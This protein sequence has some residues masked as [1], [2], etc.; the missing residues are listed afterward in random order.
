MPAH[1]IGHFFPRTWCIDG[2][3]YE[4]YTPKEKDFYT[5]DYFTKHALKYLDEYRDDDKPFFLYVAYTAPHDP[6]QAWPEDIQKYRGKFMAGYE[7]HRQERY[8]RQQEMGLID[9]S[10]PLSEPYYADWNALSEEEKAKEDTRMAIYSAMIDRV[11]QNIGKLLDKIAER[12]ELDNTLVIF[13]SDNGCAASS[14]G[15]YSNYNPTANQGAMGSMTRWTKLGRLK[16]KYSLMPYPACVGWLDRFLPGWSSQE[17]EKSLQLVRTL[18]TPNWDFHPE[19]VSHTW[20]IN[21]KT[22]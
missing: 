10:F 2:K 17:L 9:E 13:A 12:G 18:L 5:T 21:T 22:G 7:T 11:D 16:G 6:L 14:D 3:V 4:P 20:V 19:G 15:K 8:R 1:K